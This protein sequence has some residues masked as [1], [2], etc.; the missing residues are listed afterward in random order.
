MQM[1]PEA[2]RSVHSNSLLPP[3]GDCK[4]ICYILVTPCWCVLTSSLV[5]LTLWTYKHIHSIS[6]EAGLTGAA[7]RPVNQVTIH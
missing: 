6:S 2:T 5:L 3:L 4:Q 7:H 1:H